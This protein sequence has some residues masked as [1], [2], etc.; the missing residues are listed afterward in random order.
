MFLFCRFVKRSVVVVVLLELAP[1][2]IMRRGES[3]T[4]SSTLLH[5]F[6]A[7]TSS[8]DITDV[9]S[10]R[11]VRIRRSRGFEVRPPPCSPPAMNG[12]TILGM[13]G[14]FLVFYPLQIEKIMCDDMYMVFNKAI[15]VFVHC[16][17]LRGG[18]VVISKRGG[19]HP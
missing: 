16:D 19:Q 7:F 18:M 8:L 1:L 3:H 12:C 13:T 14:L 11:F 5:T 6:C 2:S 9:C 15:V 17:G 10:K 4:F